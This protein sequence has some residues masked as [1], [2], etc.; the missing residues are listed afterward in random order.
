MFLDYRYILLLASLLILLS[1]LAS[2]FAAR[3]GV[4]S[5]LATLGIGIILGNGGKYDFNYNFPELTL[6]ISEVALCFIIF[7]GG[8]NSNWKGLRPI[9]GKGLSLATIGVLSTSLILGLFVYL[10]FDWPFLAAL[11][12]GAIVSSTDAAAVF[13]ILESTGL[14]LKNNLAEILELESGTNDPMAYFLTISFSFLLVQ[15]DT[16]FLQLGLNFLISMSI[17]LVTGILGGRFGNYL[18]R[19]SKLKKGQTPVV[20]LSLV[21]LLYAVNSLLGGSPFLAVYIAGLLFSQA[22]WTNKPISIFFFEGF[23]WLMETALF[24]IL[25]LQVYIFE[26][27]DVFWEG[28]LLSVVLILLARPVGVFLSLSYFRDMHWKQKSFVSWVGLRGATPIVFALVPLV[29]QIEVAQ[30]IFNI[31][32]IVVITSILLQGTTVKPIARFTQSGSNQNS[33]L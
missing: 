29:D 11:L 6:H 23:S 13:S 20:L 12:L 24:L 31:S 30:E 5:L 19:H 32:F 25:G 9:L 22:H 27:M 8:L 21:L 28:L 18:I 14:K 16:G 10:M 15:P 7:T 3:L 26:I 17:G 1:V 4:S 33:S 2:R